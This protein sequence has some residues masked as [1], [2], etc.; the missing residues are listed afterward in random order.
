MKRLFYGLFLAP[1]FLLLSACQKP[2]PA[3]Q[4]QILGL[5]SINSASIADNA[6]IIGSLQNGAAVYTSNLKAPAF[7][8]RMQATQIHPL[9]TLLAA[10]QAAPQSQAAA[11]R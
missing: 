11:I 4:Q 1:C 3:S 10:I 5:T 7:Q 9:S 2:L 6:L 8:W